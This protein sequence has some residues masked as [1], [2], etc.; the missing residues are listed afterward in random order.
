MLSQILRSGAKKEAG[1]SEVG[2]YLDYYVFLSSSKTYY[3]ADS[4]LFNGTHVH[5]ANEYT[6]SWIKGSCT[7]VHEVQMSTFLIRLSVFQ[8]T[9]TLRHRI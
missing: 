7:N 9:L 5:S 6:A 2:H 3:N 4:Q 1:K 8:T